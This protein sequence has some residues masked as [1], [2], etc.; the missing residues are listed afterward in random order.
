MSLRSDIGLRP[1]SQRRLSRIPS[2]GHPVLDGI[3]AKPAVMTRYGGR[4]VVNGFMRHVVDVV[5]LY[6]M[7]TPL[8]RLRWPRGRR[9]RRSSEVLNGVDDCYPELLPVGALHEFKVIA[10]GESRRR[11]VKTLVENTYVGATVPCLGEY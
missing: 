1:R 4:Q 3:P 5:M 10:Q 9:G 7:T 2:G 11:R 6:N 8:R